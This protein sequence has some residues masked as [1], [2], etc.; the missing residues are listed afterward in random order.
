VYRLLP[1]LLTDGT[2]GVSYHVDFTQPPANGGPGQ[3]GPFSTWNF[4]FWYRDPQG[5]PAGF[6]LSDGLEVTF[7]P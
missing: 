5:G 4:Q 7:C 2:G 1:V 6:N 3:I